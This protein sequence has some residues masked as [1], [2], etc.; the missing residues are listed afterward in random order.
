M[1]PG[2]NVGRSADPALKGCIKGGAKGKY[3]PH[4]HTH[5]QAD[6]NLCLCVRKEEDDSIRAR[7][8]HN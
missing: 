2:E 4:T 3:I 8:G 1:A 5:T 7:A 6:R